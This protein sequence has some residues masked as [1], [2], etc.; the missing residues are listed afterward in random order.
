V[1]AV[2]YLLKNAQQSLRVAMD[3][4]LRD[5]GVTTPQYAALAFLEESP[6]LSSAQLARQAFVTPQT[7]QR[8]VANLGAAG[9]LERDPHPDLGR[10]L[11]ARLTRRGRDL[12]V[13][14]H[15][16]VQIVESRMVAGLTQDDLLRLADLLNRCAANLRPRRRP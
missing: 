15:R 3:V 11:E 16:R 12:L 14:C 1:E 4:A 2:G 6:G 13:E 5:L 9:L 10:V 8:I 7:M